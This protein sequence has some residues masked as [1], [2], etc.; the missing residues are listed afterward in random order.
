MKEVILGIDGRLL[1]VFGLSVIL[2]TISAL[3]QRKN[4][5][6]PRVRVARRLA[7]VLG[8]ATD[9]VMWR[10]ATIQ[11]G[12]AI[13]LLCYA[14]MLWIWGVSNLVVSGCIAGVLMFGLQA[15]EPKSEPQEPWR[16]Y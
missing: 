12:I 10:T 2:W 6:A 13:N 11:L 8:S 5:Y 1:I 7:I 15:L 3:S 4:R 16:D 14:T 9:K